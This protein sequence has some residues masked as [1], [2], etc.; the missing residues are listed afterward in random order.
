MV[1]TRS[2]N[3]DLGFKKKVSLLLKTAI[4]LISK[5]TTPHKLKKSHHLC[6]KTPSFPFGTQRDCKAMSSNGSLSQAL[7]LRKP[8]ENRALSLHSD[9]PIREVWTGLGILYF[10]TGPHLESHSRMSK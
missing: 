2:I 1:L 6:H 9:V 8:L 7:P 3:K 10:R 5:Q 4:K